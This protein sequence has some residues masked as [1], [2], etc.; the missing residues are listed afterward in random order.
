MRTPEHP[1]P[2]PLNQSPWLDTCTPLFYFRVNS[3]HHT[4]W[5][6]SHFPTYWVTFHFL[7]TFSSLLSSFPTFLLTSLLSFLPFLPSCFLSSSQYHHCHVFYDY[8]D[9]YYKV[10]GLQELHLVSDTDMSI[11]TL[12]SA[13]TAVELWTDIGACQRGI[14]PI[15]WVG[16]K[17]QEVSIMP[18]YSYFIECLILFLFINHITSCHKTFSTLFFIY[19]MLF[20]PI[21]I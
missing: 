13:N 15:L 4:P 7:K 21:F 2:P 5:I 14:K 16:L 9:K 11:V 6:T 3:F 18:F 20:S 1:S 10:V 19:G 8:N 17:G 12:H